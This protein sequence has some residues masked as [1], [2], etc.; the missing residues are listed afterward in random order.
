MAR[1]VGE[2]RVRSRGNREGA[3]GEP[4]ET[5]GEIDRVRRPHEHDDGKEH[6]AGAEVG[7]EPLEE[8]EDQTRAVQVVLGQHEHGDTHAERHEQLCAHL[9]AGQQAVVGAAG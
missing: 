4:V 9:V 3:D 2:R 1:H 5:V 6:V 7:N 8:R